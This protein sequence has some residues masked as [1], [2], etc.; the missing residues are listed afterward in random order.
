[1]YLRVYMILRTINI[2]M[3][4]NNYSNVVTITEKE[5]I[6]CQ[7][8][9]DSLWKSEYSHIRSGRYMDQEVSRRRMKVGNWFGFEDVMST[10]CGGQHVEL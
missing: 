5:R 6:Y 7:V 4:H 9:A 1:M 10:I 8:R 2:Y 3:S